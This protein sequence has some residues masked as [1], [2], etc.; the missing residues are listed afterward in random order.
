[1]TASTG[2]QSADVV[3]SGVEGSFSYRVPHMLASAVQVGM[4]VLVPFGH[5]RLTG[6]V[7]SV[8]SEPNPKATRNIEHILDEQP[9]FS[10]PLL[11]FTQWISEY[12]LCPWGDVLKAALPAGIAL[13]EKRHW[14]AGGASEAEIERFAAEYP[15]SL[16]LI[17]ALRNG[18]VTQQRMTKQYG[19][20]RSAALLKRMQEAG[21]I[22]FRPVLQPPRVK[23]HFDSV[24]TLA[25]AVYDRFGP[26][27]LTS[28][29]SVHEQQILREI[30]E[31]GPE[32]VLRSDMLKG[33][34]SGRRQAFTRLLGNG[35]LELRVEEVSRW[36]PFAENIPDVHEPETLTE[37]QQAA[38]SAI[39]TAVEQQRFMPFLLFGVTGSGKTQVYIEAVRRTLEKGRTSLVLLPEIA[40]TPFVWARFFRAFGDRVAIQHS[41]QSPAV[42]YDLWRAIR[43]GRYPV[44]VGARSA[45]FAPLERLGLV[46]VDEEQEASFKQED[47]PPRYHARDAALMRAHMEN[48]A[49]VLGSATPSAESYHHALNGRY[50]MLQLPERVGGASS[51]IVRIVMWKAKPKPEP[52]AEP[53]TKKSKKRAPAEELPILTDEL[54]S[55]AGEILERGKQAIFLQNRRGFSPFLVCTHCGKVPVCPDCSVSLTYHRKG[56]ALRCHYCDHREH[57]PDTCPRCGSAE[58]AAQGLG[59]QRLEEELA[60][61]FPTAR[62][63]RMDSDTASRRGMHG[64]MVSAFA[65]GEYDFL[66]GTQMIA[67]GLDFP[68]VELAAVVQADTELFYPDFRASERGASLILQVAGRAGRRETTGSVVI[69]TAVPDHPVLQTAATGKWDELLHRELAQREQGGYPP[70]SR[71]VLIRAM[72]REESA[73]VRVLLRL[74]R[75]LQQNGGVNVL[76]PAPAV[77]NR[78][79]GQYRYQMLVRTSRRD[80]AAGN[81]LRDMVRQAL[82][83]LK[84]TKNESQAII[85]V[86]VDP[87][88]VV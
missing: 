66:V 70:F 73:A 45:V 61:C 59:T 21:L 75:I 42:R 48:A 88:S 13:D 26:E 72:H 85:E 32:G 8:E 29:R 2:A 19:L 40:L 58:W 9:A 57:A 74:R 77:V 23:S 11:R 64:R 30:F 37:Y 60:V 84:R 80:D 7:V 50:T 54:K 62:I 67:K 25:P 44:V 82:M 18:P 65:A 10:P 47:T 17:E 71:L 3:F 68:L 79:R 38:V 76:G 22:E 41:A 35:S 78:I 52:E 24:V 69:Q 83:E 39:S 36:D 14:A 20:A 55:A 86:D 31:S 1:M 49:I 27:L 5:R 12:Y 56:L 34:S 51:P 6:V 43:A 4:R 53:D 46:V 33:A 63:L 16:A 28:L 81:R 87:Q 15:H